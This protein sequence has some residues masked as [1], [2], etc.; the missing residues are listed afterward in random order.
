MQKVGLSVQGGIYIIA[1]GLKLDSALCTS[2]NGRQWLQV[3]PGAMFGLGT[4]AAADLNVRSYTV[5]NR[6]RGYFIPILQSKILRPLSLLLRK[7]GRK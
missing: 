3:S 6:G 4:G 7:K 2:T 1:I 5:D